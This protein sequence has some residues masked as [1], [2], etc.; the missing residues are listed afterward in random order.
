MTTIKQQLEDRKRE[1]FA[2]LRL[3]RHIE[4]RLLPRAAAKKRVGDLPT[5]DSFKA[6]KA[7]AFLMLYN[8]IEAPIIGAVAEVY[9]AIALDRCKLIDVSQ[10]IRE[11]WIDQRFWIA[12]YDATPSTYRNRAAHLLRQTMDGVTL[13]LDARKLS[14]GGNVDGEIV[15]NL[16]TK[17]GCKLVVHRATRGGAELE[18][19]KEQRNDLAH[20]TKTF[21]ECGQAFGASDIDRIARQCLTFLAGFIRTLDKFVA[22]K[23]YLANPGKKPSSPP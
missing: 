11:L 19:V 2:Y 9:K 21:A 16:C 4:G 8:I 13:A 22:S 12:P 6:M 5:A 7:A 18:T 15:R 1:F 10:Q 23:G 17:H 14:L 3:L 20:G